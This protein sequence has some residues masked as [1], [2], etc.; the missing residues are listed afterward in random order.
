MPVPH[1]ADRLAALERAVA[2][3]ERDLRDLRAELAVARA[4]PVAP[5]AAR[6]A[7][8]DALPATDH[9]PAVARRSPLTAAALDA[10]VAA[11]ARSLTGA[12]GGTLRSAAERPDLEAMVGRYGTVAVAAL[13]ILTGVGAF[14]TWAV[15]RITITPETRV[16]MGAVL[17]AAMAAGG[18]RLRSAAP[19]AAPTAEPDVAAAGREGTRRFGDVLL[20]LALAVT[21][22]DAWAA[23]PYLGIVPPGGALAVAAAAS[24]GLAALA[25][26]GRQQTLFVIGVG[27]A[28]VAPFI[29]GSAVG[30]P[31]AL[32]TYG[33]L[34]LAA[35]LAAIPSSAELLRRWRPSVRI[36]GLAGTAYTV[37]LL[38]DALDAP[39]P[40]A[41]RPAL[42]DA[43]W[44]LPLPALFALACAAVPLALARRQAR[45]ADS[46]D[47]YVARSTLGGLALAYHATATTALVTLAASAPAA[48]YRL[49][50]LALP[51]TVGSYVCLPLLDQPDTTLPPSGVWPSGSPLGVTA[52][53][54]ALF[55]PLLLLSA[56]L[57]ALHD[58]RG[59]RGAA[60]SAMWAATA[61]LAAWW[62]L[63]HGASGTRPAAATRPASPTNPAVAGAHVAVA[64][65]ASALGLVLLL[66]DQDVLRVALLAVHAAVAVQLLRVIR[67]PLALLAPA[68]VASVATAWAGTLLAGRPA[69]A[70]T[71]F[72]TPESLAAVCVVAA[73]C[74]IARRV[75]HEE[76][77]VF[78][79]NDRGIVV[80]AAA[81]VAL[82][83]GR[84]ELA[85]AFSPDVATFL[86][87]GY[88]AVTGIG[89]IALGRARSVPAARQV[90]LAL[91]LYAALKAFAQASGLD[92]V[93]LRVG[94]YLLVGGFLLAVGYWYRAA[95]ARAE[96]TEPAGPPTPSPNT[97]SPAV[98][99]TPSPDAA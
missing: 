62:W 55:L 29:T 46:T 12:P 31:A 86:L 97:P 49:I 18:W 98:P 52:A 96:A 81:G 51:A 1:D 59:A 34:V 50:A 45:R 85:D 41:L 14:L 42:G 24:A 89:A 94:S 23:G 70:Y 15:N 78:S 61:A 64:G 26:R 7:A 25:W 65:L 22:V 90:G 73:W 47:G 21:H 16:A 57:G 79:R 13:L 19:P 9:A 76:S 72:L 30:R 33:W 27:G 66:P 39:R 71:P 38:T 20:A 40:G 56:A 43:S 53:G 5:P 8:P 80:A 91:A 82:L 17:A 75:S 4:V 58:I 68:V 32:A 84:Q 69:Y 99:P 35:G 10:R 3:L 60:V 95:G 6:P 28:L 88:F 63:S 87:I 54:I 77:R 2:D 67:E 48:D 92:A 37:A 11:Y 36:L 44:T 83:W 74:T 93:G